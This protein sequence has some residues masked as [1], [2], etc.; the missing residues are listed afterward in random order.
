MQATLEPLLAV[1]AMALLSL[2]PQFSLLGKSI[3]MCVLL[4]NITCWDQEHPGQTHTWGKAR[5]DKAL[6]LHF[7]SVMFVTTYA[8]LLS[9]ANLVPLIPSGLQ[10]KHYLTVITSSYSLSVGWH[11][12]VS[13]LYFCSSSKHIATVGSSSLNFLQLGFPVSRCRELHSPF[14]DA[15]A[16]QFQ[17]ERLTCFFPVVC[18]HE[19]PKSYWHI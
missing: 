4:A 11:Y 18:L 19:S 12:A 1:W 3:T 13:F 7:L 10:L 6:L 5:D 9:Y 15:I 16:R 2:W 17:E 14:P 8:S